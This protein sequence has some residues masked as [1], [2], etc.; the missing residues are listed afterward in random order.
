M[1]PG[2]KVSVDLPEGD[3]TLIRMGHTPT[4]AQNEPSPAAGLGPVLS[5]QRALVDEVDAGP[6]GLHGRLGRLAVRRPA[7]RDLAEVDDLTPI[8]A[9]PVMHGPLVYFAA[10][11]QV[12]K[13]D[14]LLVRRA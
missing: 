10:P 8:R 3:W 4:G 12:L 11:Q 13:A 1:E 14:V 7:V 6:D 9:E 5:G 2:G